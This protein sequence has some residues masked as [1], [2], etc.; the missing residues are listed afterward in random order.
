MRDRLDVWSTREE[1][2]EAIL[3]PHENKAELTEAEALAA[4]IQFEVSMKTRSLP[5]LFQKTAT[6]ALQ[7]WYIETAE[8]PENTGIIA[9]TWGQVDGKQQHTVDTIREG[10]NLGKKNATSAI[11]QAELEAEARWTKQLKKGYVKTVKEAEAGTVD[12]II[13]GGIAPMLAPSKIYPHFAK[14]LAWPV[15]V[16]PKLDGT[17]CV[18]VVKDGVC[19]LWSRTRK[20]IRSVPHI[21]AA[22][23]RMFPSGNHIVD[24]ELYNHLLRNDFEE[25]ISLIRQDEPGEGHERVQYF[26]YD[27]PSCQQNF[28][29]RYNALTDAMEEYWGELED[30][31]D[32]PLVLVPTYV[33]A[34]HADVMEFHDTNL[35]AGYE[36]SMVRNDGPYEQDKRSYHLQKLK[37]FIDGE[38]SITAAEEGRGKDAGTVGAFVCV[39]PDGKEFKARLKATYA[40]RRQLFENPEQWRGKKMTVAYQNLTSDGIPRFPIGK[41]IGEDK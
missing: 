19:T 22:V 23:A 35:A 6:G 41:A 14:K 40:R 12:A 27:Y 37:N 4:T 36:G 8:G 1:I 13:E 21:N 39:M 24:G 10:K 5:E 16:Q 32:T 38:F 3:Q 11:Q 29:S 34:C 25:L 18:A 9:T 7:R 30:S 17:R 26:V 28:S 2:I 31:E 33:A 20:P 15:Y